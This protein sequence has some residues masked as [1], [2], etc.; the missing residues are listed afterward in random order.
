MVVPS[1]AQELDRVAE[2]EAGDE[3][4]VVAAMAVDGDG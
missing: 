2:D 1:L 4:V 3:V